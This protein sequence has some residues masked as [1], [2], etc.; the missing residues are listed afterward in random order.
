MVIAERYEHPFTLLY[1]TQEIGILYLRAGD[2]ADAVRVLSI[3]H[4]LALEM[5]NNLLRPAAMAELGVALVE[6]GRL[7]E[8]LALLEESLDCARSL[9]LKPQYGQQLSYLARGRLLAG[10]LDKARE[11]AKQALDCT[12]TYGERGDEAWVRLLLTE[13]EQRRDPE[14][15]R[16]LLVDVQHLA[17]RRGFVTLEKLCRDRLQHR[18]AA[19]TKTLFGTH[20]SVGRKPNGASTLH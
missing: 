20:H 2:V 9:Q 6:S 18:N 16:R 17:R 8:G 5:P 13:I 3:G 14:E 7:A 10:E 15:A 4:R 1:V 12:L 11:L 19:A